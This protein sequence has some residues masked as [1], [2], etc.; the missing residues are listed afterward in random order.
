VLFIIVLVYLYGIIREKNKVLTANNAQI[1]EQSGKL[2]V[3]MKG[4]APPGE[5]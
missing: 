1:N 5:K 2:Q 3:L 4:T